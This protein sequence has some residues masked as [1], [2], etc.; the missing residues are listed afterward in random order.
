MSTLDGFYD[1]YAA[2]YVIWANSAAKETLGR[3]FVGDGGDFSPCFLMTELFDQCGWTG[4]GFMELSRQ[5]RAVTP[6]VHTQ[7]LY[8]VDGQLTDI[9]AP[10]DQALL[11]QF[12]SAEYFRE[13]QLLP[14][15]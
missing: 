4:P 10:E 1:Y 12:L 5:V 15:E 13:N 7:G 6:L 8:L 3:D 11:D 2:P 9:L 14:V